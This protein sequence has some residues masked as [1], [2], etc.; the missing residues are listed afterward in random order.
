MESCIEELRKARKE[1]R[2]ATTVSG[3]R[4]QELEK[5]SIMN[6]KEHKGIGA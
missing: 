1:E 6:S 5:D 3:E 2:E 4:R